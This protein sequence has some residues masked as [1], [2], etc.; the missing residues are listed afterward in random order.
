[1]NLEDL[2]KIDRERS[3]AES[4]AGYLR[5]AQQTL[6]G[7]RGAGRPLVE[8]LAA[9]H[10]DTQYQSNRLMSAALHVAVNA[11]KDD[12]IRVA[13]LRL[14]AAARELST[15]AGQLQAQLDAY[16]VNEPEKAQ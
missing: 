11:V 7:H 15:R 14:E 10:R 9:V 12:V 13:E 1:M 5:Y 16:L 8:I 2:K 6:A 4:Q 3:E